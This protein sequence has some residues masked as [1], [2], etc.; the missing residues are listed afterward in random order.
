MPELYWAYENA[1]CRDAGAIVPEPPDMTYAHRTL[2]AAKD[3]AREAELGR[4]VLPFDCPPVRLIAGY[5]FQVYCPGEV[6]LKR[7]DHR[8][9]LRSFATNHASFGLADI[10]GDPWP[11]SDS[12]LVASWISGSEFVKIQTGIMVFFPI[13]TYLY[14]GPLPNAGLDGDGGADVMAGLEYPHAKR[15]REIAGATYG[16]SC[17][18]VIV[19]LPPQGQVVKLGRGDPLAWFFAVPKRAEVSLTRYRPIPSEA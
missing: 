18:N 17:L 10:G 13:D 8:R 15:Q 2:P 5:G 3:L 14:Q 1:A 6:V 19:R 11:Q 16:W 12:G 9:R 7:A 4:P